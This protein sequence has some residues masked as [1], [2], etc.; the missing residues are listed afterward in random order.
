MRIL[1]KMAVTS[2]ISSE[3]SGDDREEIPGGC[4]PRSGLTGGKR[5][6]M[7]SVRRNRGVRNRSGGVREL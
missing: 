2:C 4:M 5:S 7:A 6:V 1:L 3:R